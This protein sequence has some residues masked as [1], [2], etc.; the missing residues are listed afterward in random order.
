ME[1]EKEYDVV[2]VGAGPTGAAAAKALSKED[3]E[4][5]IVERD[6]LP[7]YKMCSGIV[8]PSS[9][10]YISDHFGDI[11]DNFLCQPN[12]VK[13]FRIYLTGDNPVIENPFSESSQREPI[14]DDGLNIWRSDLDYWL[15]AQSSAVLIDRC[16]F[17]GYDKNGHEYSIRLR[18]HNQSFSV[19]TRFLIGADGTLSR[20]R[21]TAFPGFDKTVGLIPNYEEYFRGQIDL[22]PGWLYV[23]MDRSITGYFATVFHKDDLIVVVT[24]VSQ[25]E[26]AREY[27]QAFQE[28]LTKKHGL[29]IREKVMSHAIVLT[30]MSATRNYCL[31]EADILLAGEAGG[32]LRGAEGITSSLTSGWAAGCAV[33]ESIRSGKPAIDHFRELTAEEMSICDT[34]HENMSSVLG[35]NVFARP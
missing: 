3:L 17:D 9:R 4:I 19:K 12:T 8:F 27:F 23:F 5:L 24:G 35:F 31:G 1:L 33:L 29:R 11:P 16:R 25:R 34:N 2:I 30:D 6:K 21:R 28:Y 22:E 10:Q 14:E 20:V 18:V 32:F 7:R 13:G 15:C 26:S